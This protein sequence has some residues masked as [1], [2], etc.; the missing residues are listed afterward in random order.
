MTI[1]KREGK[2]VSK[3]ILEEIDTQSV[4]KNFREK[5]FHKDIKYKKTFKND[6]QK[7]LYDSDSDS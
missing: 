1:K 3:Y 6:K 2:R 4:E 5:N 7:D